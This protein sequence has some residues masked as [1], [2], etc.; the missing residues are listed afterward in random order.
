METY[1]ENVDL[2]VF[3]SVKSYFY[4]TIAI[5]MQIDL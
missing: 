5:S 3:M 1:S 2:T 4:E